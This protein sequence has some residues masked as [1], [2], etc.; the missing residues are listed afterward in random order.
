MDPRIETIEVKLVGVQGLITMDHDVGEDL[1]KLCGRLFNK[2]DAIPHVSRSKRTVGYWH[3][4]DNVTRL[5]FAGVEVDTFE[6]FSWDHEYGLVVWS[7]GSTTWAIWKEK[8]GG[9]GS[10][11]HGGVCYGWL[12]ESDYEWDYRFIGEFEVYYWEEFG[13]KAQ[14]E[15]HEIWIPIVGKPK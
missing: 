9:E 8:D 7:L 5:Y 1:R 2:L 11:T 13:E 6:D 4:V 14:S 12:S 3:F 10:I 15:V